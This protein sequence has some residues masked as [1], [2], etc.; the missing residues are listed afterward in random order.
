[1]SNVPAK[2]HEPTPGQTVGPFFA[3]G[4]DFAKKH[5]KAAPN[6]PSAIALRGTVYDGA[7]NPIPD[8]IIE[9]W[10]ADADGSVPRARGSLARNDLDFTGYGRAFTNDDGEYFFWTRKPGSVSREAQYLLPIVYARGP[11]AT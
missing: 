10:Q 7:G 9:V 8:A 2:T 5:E 6:S 3:F 11:P 4:T 1:M